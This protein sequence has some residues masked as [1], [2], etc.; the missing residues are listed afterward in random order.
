[1]I[2]FLLFFSLRATAEIINAKKN[3]LSLPSP[4]WGGRH[5]VTWLLNSS[6]YNTFLVLLPPPPVPPLA[7]SYLFP[8][9]KHNLVVETAVLCLLLPVSRHG[10]VTSPSFLDVVR[11]LDWEEKRSCGPA[12]FRPWKCQ[13]TQKCVCVCVCDNNGVHCGPVNSWKLSMDFKKLCTFETFQQLWGHYGYGGN[14]Q[15]VIEQEFTRTKGEFSSVQY[16]LWSVF[17]QKSHIRIL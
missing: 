1:M 14:F 11:E 13:W 4:W 9:R 2:C 12:D 6:Y 15:E 16:S 10:G 7:I 5:Y 3:A 8:S 17:I